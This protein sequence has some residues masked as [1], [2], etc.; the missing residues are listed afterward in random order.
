MERVLACKRQDTDLVK[1]SR[2]KD[3]QAQV[4]ILQ[5]LGHTCG[6]TYFKTRNGS[7]NGRQSRTP[8][9]D[10]E[11]IQ[12]APWAAEGLRPGLK[13]KSWKNIER[14]DLV[15]IATRGGRDKHKGQAWKSRINLAWSWI[16]AAKKDKLESVPQMHR[17]LCLA[18]TAEMPSAA[19]LRAQMV[20][21]L[22][23][24]TLQSGL[25]VAPSSIPG[26]GFG[27]FT[28]VLILKG[29]TVTYYDGVAFILIKQDWEKHKER[30]GWYKA[31]GLTSKN[32]ASIAGFTSMDKLPASA[33]VVSLMNSLSPPQANCK[34]G[35]VENKSRPLLVIDRSPV[36]RV[37]TV[38][39]A[40]DIEPGTE[41]FWDY[42]VS[43]HGLGDHAVF[44]QAVR[45][46]VVKLLLLAH[47]FDKGCPLRA[48]DPDVLQKILSAVL[49]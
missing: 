24:L 21:R 13:K 25:Y 2:V 9:L 23:C 27:L 38:V 30:L 10:Q 42:A 35:C 26:G 36:F 29:R 31:I 44:E 5:A 8:E 3:T 19:L 15:H 49:S 39:A 43:E 33:G 48:L 46:A 6:A 28:S 11:I 1:K 17:L 22:N 41:L 16:T 12:P 20:E 45:C 34:E 32:C 14:K 37:P 47:R 7:R 18:P 40:R 4:L